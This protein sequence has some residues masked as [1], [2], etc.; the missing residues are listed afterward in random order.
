MQDNNCIS[1][2]DG[3]LRLQKTLRT[4]KDFWKTFYEL[5]A[6]AFYNYTTI[7]ISF[8]STETPDLHAD[9]AEFY[10]CIYKLL[11]VYDWQEAVFQMAIEP[12]IFIIAQ[13]PIDP[14]KWVMPKKF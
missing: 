5:W 8:F 6:D 14:L 3:M 2:E 12:H 13:Q 7:F 10:S 11:M 1:I 4:Y 9:L